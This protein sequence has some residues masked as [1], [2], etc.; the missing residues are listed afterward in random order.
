MV[1]AKFKPIPPD[2]RIR[3]L[4]KE[5]KALQKEDP[6][7]E[8]AERLAA[9]ARAAHEERQLNMAMHTAQLC[10]D[11]D[12]GAP[13]MLLA[14]Y[15]PDGEDDPEDALRTWQDLQD[16]ARYVDRPDVRE[17][18]DQKIRET[19]T[20]WIASADDAERRHRMRTLTSMFDR[21]FAD[22]IHD[23]TRF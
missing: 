17:T 8:R 20:A 18:A 22:E 12:P 16:L 2:E 6:S 10:L 15:Q 21:A 11:E 4:R 3:E 5:L 19:A 9:F 23:A 7:P 14:A 1:R 13:A